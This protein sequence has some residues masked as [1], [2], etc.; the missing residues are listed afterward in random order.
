MTYMLSIYYFLFFCIQVLVTQSLYPILLIETFFLTKKAF[1]KRSIKF[2]SNACMDNYISPKK[3]ET[4]VNEN[5]FS[6]IYSEGRKK[7]IPGIRIY[8]A[9]ATC[10]LENAKKTRQYIYIESPSVEEDQLTFKYTSRMKYIFIV[11]QAFYL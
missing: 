4:Q 1:S 10:H 5:Q 9:A 2:A 6:S 11:K 7:G 3:K 8:T